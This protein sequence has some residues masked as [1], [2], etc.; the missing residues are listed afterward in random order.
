ML[1]KILND[2]IK[3][4]NKNWDKNRKSLCRLPN[5]VEQFMYI[6]DTSKIYQDGNGYDNLELYSDL[7][8]RLDISDL[9][10]QWCKMDCGSCFFVCVYKEKND[11]YI[12]YKSNG[13]HKKVWLSM[14]IQNN[15][16]VE[17]KKVAVEI[18]WVI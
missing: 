6:Y 16:I 3:I 4:F 8:Q 1:R 10:L 5:F 12:E 14:W 17:K 13:L 15:K 18:D 2:N 9:R 11:W 7:L